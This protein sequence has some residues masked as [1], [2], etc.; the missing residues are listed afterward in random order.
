MKRSEDA[1]KR[2]TARRIKRAAAKQRND[3]TALW[4]S[5]A[6]M[7]SAV[8]SVTS[9]S[10]KQELIKSQLRAIKQRFKVHKN[11][12]YFSHQKHALTTTELK[13][14]LVAMIGQY[15]APSLS[16]SA[17]SSSSS[18]ADAASSPVSYLVNALDTRA[19]VRN[20]PY[21]VLQMTI[22]LFVWANGRLVNVV[23]VYQRSDQHRRCRKSV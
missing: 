7:N 4:P 1:A 12:I 16:A 6:A 19:K 10:K 2:N 3:E 21:D 9:D 14:M 20:L 17:A 18:S 22:F 8:A 13:Q 15:V 5:A 23:D 11:T